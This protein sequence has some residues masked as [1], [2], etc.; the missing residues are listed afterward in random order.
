MM[1]RSITSRLKRPVVQHRPA[2]GDDAGQAVTQ[3]GQREIKLLVHFGASS[4]FICGLSSATIR[5][6]L[7]AQAMR[8]F[9]KVSKAITEC[10]S[11]IELQRPI[12]LVRQ[13]NE[14]ARPIATVDFAEDQALVLKILNPADGSAGRRV[15]AFGKRR[16]AAMTATWLRIER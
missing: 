15:G 3:D 7:S 2:G 6:S 5:P 14:F 9:F 13:M 1:R 12:G 10:L 4:T 8:A 16:N 11:E